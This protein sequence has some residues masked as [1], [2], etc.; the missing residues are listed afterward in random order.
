MS[1]VHV[2]NNG[3]PNPFGDGTS[4]LELIIEDAEDSSPFISVVLQDEK[5]QAT[6]ADV[7]VDTEEDADQLLMI[8]VNAVEAF[9]D[10][11]A[12]AQ[13]KTAVEKVPPKHASLGES[14]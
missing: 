13:G 2:R 14:A 6:L 7:F 10:K 3:T 12:K 1:T 5:T 8:V 9:K 11:Y 4:P